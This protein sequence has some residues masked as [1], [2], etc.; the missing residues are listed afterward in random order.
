[1]HTLR[2]CLLPQMA[3]RSDVTSLQ[4]IYY[5]K[6][7]LM[8]RPQIQIDRFQICLSFCRNLA[9]HNHR[10]FHYI[11]ILAYYLQSLDFCI[12]YFNTDHYFEF[13]IYH[14]I[15]FFT[16]RF[17]LSVPLSCN[18]WLYSYCIAQF[19]LYSI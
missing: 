7:R 14:H 8:S 3:S 1:M 2:L 12:S 13:E 9:Y 5:P 4:Y 6:T 11:C 15:L 18:T 16:L 19:P 10:T 17:L